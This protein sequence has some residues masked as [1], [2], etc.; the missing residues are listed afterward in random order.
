MKHH[1]ASAKNGDPLWQ[2]GARCGGIHVRGR[3]LDVG[4][5]VGAERQS[6]AVS[7]EEAGRTVSRLR[8]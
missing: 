1:Q 8:R 2:A 3:M 5:S 7:V 6:E 4:T